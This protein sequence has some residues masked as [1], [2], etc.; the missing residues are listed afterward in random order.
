MLKLLLIFADPAEASA[1]LELFPFSA[2]RE[3]F[4]YHTEAFLI[5]VLILKKWG[6]KGVIHALTPPPMGY[7]RWIN[8]G[9]AGACNPDIPLLTTYTTASV[10]I[11]NDQGSPETSYAVTPVPSLPIAQ[12]TSVS[13][14]YR[15]GFHKQWQLVDMEGFFIAQQASLISCPCSMIKVSSDYTIPGGGNFLK[16]NKARLSQ[17]LAESLQTHLLSFTH[18]GTEFPIFRAR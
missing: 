8:L 17:K 2:H 1:T 10:K 11:F 12:L 14:P 15:K 9:F 7:H 4:S 5:D 18:N 16:K 6:P 3:F 13:S